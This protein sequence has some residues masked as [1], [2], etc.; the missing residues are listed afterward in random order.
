MDLI[1]NC[2]K[3]I[4]IDST[5]SHGSKEIGE[6]VAHLAI[7]QGLTVD[8][9]LEI[10]NGIE[11]MNVICRIDQERSKEEFLLQTHL[12]TSDPGPFSLWTETGANPFDATIIDGKIYGLGAAE[13]KLDFL[14][15]LVAISFFKDINHWKTP[16]V[17]VGTFGEEIGMLGAL[18]LMRKNKINSKLAVIGA[19]SDLQIINSA[20][21]FV[22]VEIRIPFSSEE[23]QY[24]L[25]HNLKESTSTQS[26]IFTGKSAHS[27]TPHL[28][29]SAIVKMFDY[30]SKLPR[31]LALMEIDGGTNFNSV[32][33][34]AFLE[35]D[36]YTHRTRT[37]LA[38]IVDIY[39]GLK[40]LEAQFVEFKD[41]EF[42]PDHPTL[43]I[44][45]IR[46]L[47]DCVVMSGTCR[48]SPL[49][50][51]PIYEGWMK[52]LNEVCDQNEAEFKILDYKKPFRTSVDSG[53]LLGA[54]DILKSM[55]KNFSC[56]GQSSTNE[57]S[58]FSRMGI[59]C[60]CF[61][62]GVREGNAHTP[63]E[64]VRIEDLKSAIE[65]YKQVILR[66]CL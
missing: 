22:S 37:T 13:T 47:D 23:S 2:R 15:K 60:I 62:P 41:P 14:C 40:H 39:L 27:S 61:G 51:Q 21:G 36:L 46:T 1:E 4:S 49:I 66:F 16:P 9:Q 31:D 17:L 34:H 45:Y 18:K 48:M 52:Y 54:Q 57:A 58:L 38:R 64:H 56:V 11:Q 7:Q 50:T 3:I 32:A 59:D 12:D 33:S 44:G 30:V 5:P 10:V 24:R 28:G 8:T 6:F 20:K 19:P 26:K 29:D 55:G 63:Y 35:I 25:E 43:N 42:T 65:F 53:L